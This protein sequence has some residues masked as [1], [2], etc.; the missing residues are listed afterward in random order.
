MGQSVGQGPSQH[1]S[2]SLPCHS[3]NGFPCIQSS[4][5]GPKNLRVQRKKDELNL[6]REVSINLWNAKQAGAE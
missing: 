4:K 6:K 3:L 1:P 5:C 2:P